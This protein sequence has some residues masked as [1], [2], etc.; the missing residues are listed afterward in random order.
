MTEN[1]AGDKLDSNAEKKI[2]K[3]A[4]WEKQEVSPSSPDVGRTKFDTLT[5]QEY[6]W[7]LAHKK[8]SCGK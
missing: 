4:Y 6:A 8:M 5:A 7:D 2:V 1:Q 3:G